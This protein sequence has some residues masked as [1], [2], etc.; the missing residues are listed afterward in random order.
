MVDVA[1]AAA[2]AAAVTVFVTIE[3]MASNISGSTVR[4]L[5]GCAVVELPGPAQ[6]GS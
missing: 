4:I 2:L 5:S 6:I 3:A 1:L